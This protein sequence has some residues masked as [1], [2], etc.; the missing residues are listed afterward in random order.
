[1]TDH[2]SEAMRA[3]L[4][5]TENGRRWSVAEQTLADLAHRFGWDEVAADGTRVFYNK[6]SGDERH[7]TWPRGA[8]RSKH[9]EVFLTDAGFIKF[10]E[11]RTYE[12]GRVDNPRTETY[13]RSE[14][15][16][17]VLADIEWF[18]IEE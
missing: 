11:V 10:W 18:K 4:R 15:L 5:D 7:G 9:I 2:F 6:D 16:Y 1:M 3:R 14:G 13:H 12:R 17:E 8:S